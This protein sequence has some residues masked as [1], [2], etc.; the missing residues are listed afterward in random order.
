MATLLAMRTRA[1]IEADQD[2]AT[3]PTDAQYTSWINDGMR[4]VWTDLVTAGWPANY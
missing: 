2:S 1:R 4:E 3:F